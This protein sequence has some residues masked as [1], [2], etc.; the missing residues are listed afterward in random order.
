LAAIRSSATSRTNLEG[1]LDTPAVFVHIPSL[2]EPVVGKN[3]PSL[4]LELT[5]KA[6]GVIVDSLSLKL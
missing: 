1:G 6:L 3:L 4:S 5:A 2:P